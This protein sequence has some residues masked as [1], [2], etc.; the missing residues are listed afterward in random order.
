MGVPKF[1]IDTFFKQDAARI[2]SARE[3]GIAIHKTKDIDAAG[4]EIELPVRDI[5]ANR[6]PKQ[7]YVGQGHIVDSNLNTSGQFD[8]LIADNKGSPLLFSSEN[9]TDYLTYESI[10]ALGEIKSTFYKSK[11][12][13][14]EFTN[15]I[16]SVNEHLSRRP[17]PP[18]Q[19]TQDFE[20]ASGGVITITSS[21]DRP[22]KNPLFKFMFFVNS[23]DADFGQ[24]CMT[25]NSTDNRNVPNVVVFLDRGII[26]KAEIHA[27]VVMNTGQPGTSTQLIPG[28]VN[29]YPEFTKPDFAGL[30]R[31]VFYE[32][33]PESTSASCLAYIVYALNT[34]ITNCMVLKPDLIK[35][36]NGLFKVRQATI[37]G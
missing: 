20:F 3:K 18:N 37:V 11:K 30:Q 22:Y 26:L 21:E 27:T 28:A 8:I 29:L 9:G 17:T 25:L 24:I 23:G 32:F 36:H 31:S 16:N 33:E 12:Y 14:E 7:Y 13:I 34:H 1:D 35:Y 2:F 4:D 10:F 6:L 19:V 5:I 15:K